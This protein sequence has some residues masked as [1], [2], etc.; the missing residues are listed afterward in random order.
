[1]KTLNLNCDLGEGGDFDARLMPHI[2][3]CNIACGGHSGT[4]KTVAE[5]VKL[6]IEHKVKIGAHPSYPD[7][8]NFGRQPMVLPAKELKREVK[9]Q[10]LI[11]VEAL[12]EYGQKLHHVKPHGALYNALVTDE[13][14]AKA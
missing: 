6:A 5:T 9:R 14:K 8:E 2:S 1:M 3:A 12:K 11:V 7:R 4:A 10:I 13:E